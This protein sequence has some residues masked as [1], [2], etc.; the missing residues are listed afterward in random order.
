MRIA[1][2]LGTMITGDQRDIIVE[3]AIDPRNRGA[4][5]F[6]LHLNDALNLPLHHHQ[7]AQILGNEKG[8]R[9]PSMH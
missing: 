1:M 5:P 6:Q 4:I 9:Y 3:T 7:K 2:T 8:L